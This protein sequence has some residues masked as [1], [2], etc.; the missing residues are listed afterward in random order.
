[1]SKEEK[2]TGLGLSVNIG[3]IVGVTTKEEEKKDEKP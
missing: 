1:M 3:S 2:K